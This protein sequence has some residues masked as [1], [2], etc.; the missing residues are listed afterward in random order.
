MKKL[1]TI[2]LT[3]AMI[4]SLSACGTKVET[5]TLTGTGKGYGGDVTV[6]VTMEGDK[7]TKVVAKGDKETA[8]VG[9]KAIEQLPAK[10][11]EKNS[12]D[13]DVVA[14][15]TVT[16]RALIYAVKNALDPKAN[17]WPI[18]DNTKPGEVTADTIF[19]G[20]G[21]SNMARTGPGKDDKD[22]QVW[23]LNNVYADVLFD[24]DGKILYVYVDQLE[25]ASPNYDG[26][27]MPHLSGWPGQGGYNFDEN[28][29]EKVD[30]K[31]PD[32]EDNFKAEVALWK[33]KRQ[34]GAEYKVG[35]STWQ[36]QM[37]SYQK[38]FVG[39]TIAEIEAW[40]KKFTS[41]RNG[42]PLKDGSTD[43][44]DKAK[45]DALT[46]AEKADLAEVTA[47]A[48]ISL[49]DAHGNIIEAIKNA[50]ANKQ[51]L[52]I[53]E[54]ASTGFGVSFMPRIGPGKDDKDVQ[55]YSFNEV[56]VNTLFDKDGKIAYIHI[57]QLEIASPNYDGAGM[58]HF[59]GWPGQGGYNFDE[60]HDEKVDGKTPDTEENFKAE[61]SLWKSKRERGADY[62][63]GISTWHE[64]MDAFEKLF[65][66]KTV[67]EIETWFKK[68][69]SDRNGRPLK[70]GSADAADKAKYDA[71][72][73]AEKADLAEV[74][75]SATMSLNDAHGNIIEAIKASF[76]NKE[77]LA[78]KVK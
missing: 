62:K 16:S 68:Y 53:T 51:Q 42:R 45:Y 65:T 13:V 15:A 57:D 14:G 28:H 5:K 26:A 61:V 60:N 58:P 3:A 25:V 46:A 23:S 47:T 22:T 35:I 64:Q 69:T 39:M 40:N 36:E 77:P 56:V 1:T 59:S 19:H 54:A 32:T 71:L 30:G 37:D 38:M 8:G 34:R 12:A 29:D 27:G 48:T 2:I 75:A 33:T 76:A 50:Y 4:A 20:L 67:A 66:G 44:A 63:V 43:A 18:V 55:V 31:T 24:K 70:D 17:P 72:T 73:A 49:T 41:D 9:S 6:T 74:T 78:L 11:V 10:F 52:K 21:F 7:I